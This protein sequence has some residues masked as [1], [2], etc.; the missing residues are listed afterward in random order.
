MG[1]TLDL[2]Q[3]ADIGDLQG[4]T[5]TVNMRD[6]KIITAPGAD[7]KSNLPSRN[8]NSN[9]DLVVEEDD[10]DAARRYC[11]SELELLKKINDKL[12]NKVKR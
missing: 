8:V 2:A 4:Q 12:K 9:L 11:E 7:D 3:N 5:D 6:D 10:E 1:E